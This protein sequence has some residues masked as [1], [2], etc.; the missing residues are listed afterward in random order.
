LPVGLSTQNLPIGMQLMG[1]PFKESVILNLA[2]QFQLNTDFHKR[3][4]NL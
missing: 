4:P 1:A 2:H 3:Q